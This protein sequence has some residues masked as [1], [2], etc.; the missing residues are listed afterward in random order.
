MFG[1]RGRTNTN[2][3]RYAESSTWPSQP[4][5]LEARVGPHP[6]P[7]L[8]AR[9]PSP[10]FSPHRTKGRLDSSVLHLP[11]LFLF[12]FLLPLITISSIVIMVF[13]VLVVSASTPKMNTLALRAEQSRAEQSRA[14]Q[15]R[16]RSIASTPP[17]RRSLPPQ[18]RFILILRKSRG[19]QR[20]RHERASVRACRSPSQRF[21]YEGIA[22]HT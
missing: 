21:L 8:R 22:Q 6:V 14:E 3:L 11:A 13:A 12:F 18:L 17:R 15:S 1:D 5:R 7:G 16:T 20:R 19:R 4:D 10:K 2:T 9:A